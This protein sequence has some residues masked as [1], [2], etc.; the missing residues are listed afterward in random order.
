MTERRLFVISVIL[1]IA[2]GFAVYAGTLNGG[3][4][5]DDN[6]FVRDNVYIRNWQYL[7]KLFTENLGTGVGE[8]YS[9]YRPIQMLTYAADYSLWRLNV[10]GYHL[11]NICLHI[12]VALSL[13]RLIY[14]LFGDR[15]LSF[16][17]SLFFVIHPIHTG[18]VASI[19][20]RADPLSAVFILIGLLLYIRNSESWN[21]FRYF[22]IVSCFAFGVLSRE[23]ALILP[24]LLILYHA[25]FSRKIDGKSIVSILVLAAI[26]IGLRVGVFSYLLPH[27]AIG[28]TFFER[29]P[30]VFAAIANYARLLVLPF[31]L[32]MVY[33]Q[34]IFQFSDH[35]V[36]A[37]IIIALAF[38]LILFLK[39]KKSKLITFSICWSLL[40][41]IPQSNVYPLNA[42]MAEHWLYLPSIGFFLILAK[43][44][45]LMMRKI[46]PRQVGY[47]VI[48]LL[49]FFYSFLTVM[50]NR[51]W[52]DPVVFY[53]KNLEYI[54]ES[55]W[56]Y[57]NLGNVYYYEDKIEEAVESYQKA[58]NLDPRFDNAYY[59]LANAFSDMGKTEESLSLFR[60][61]IELNPDFSNAYGN[62]GVVL[63]NLG[64]RDEAVKYYRKA[65]D[66]K[67]DYAD[68]Y[69]NLGN[70]YYS[71]GNA[72]DAI[73]LF[74]KAIE[75]D[76]RH[77]EAH[78]N[79]ATAYLSVGVFDNAINGYKEVLKI[80]PEHALAH[81]NLAIAYFYNK[82]YDKAIKYCD[83][84]LKLGCKI[85]KDFLDKVNSYKGR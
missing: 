63:Y 76:S 42:Y 16:L 74:N 80:D 9:F 40:T 56:M 82:E 60:K 50:Q 4:V 21:L 33:G 62:M 49:L 29:L 69:Y 15:V 77:T 36:V 43:C 41:F 75:V 83:R 30:G 26:Y 19:S 5:W 57:N 1:I 20:G 55:A 28:T 24:A 6:A 71:E 23:N 81:K 58:I 47:I 13:F 27:T 53:K 11:T 10:T 61:V 32:R 38:V 72:E 78:H 84:A 51:I 12:L 85:D 34:A 66:L 44:L 39:G 2:A 68:A 70:A 8:R 64:R 65:I 52:R 25:I 18:A 3:F 14:L 17:A 45:A 31:G 46:K 67:P 59:N 22:G 48:L 7:P 37:G 35:V 79:I 73:K 54:P